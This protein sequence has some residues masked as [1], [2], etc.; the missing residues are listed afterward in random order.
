M[1]YIFET[2]KGLENLA[3][4]YERLDGNIQMMI[5]NGMTR[6]IHVNFLIVQYFMNYN[7]I[8]RNDREDPHNEYTKMPLSEIIRNCAEHYNIKPEEL[9]EDFLRYTGTEFLDKE[10]KKMVRELTLT[11][12]ERKELNNFL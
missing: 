3:N 10:R 9:N 7:G 11:D 1:T 2:L 12:E 5:R 6:K 8:I 4:D